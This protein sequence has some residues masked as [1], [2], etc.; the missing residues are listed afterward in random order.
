MNKSDKEQ[1]KIGIFW[2]IINGFILFLLKNLY[3]AFS[4]KSN[5]Y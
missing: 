1:F 3:S 2:D 4:Y 5:S